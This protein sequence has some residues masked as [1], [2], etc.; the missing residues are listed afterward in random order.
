MVVDKLLFICMCLLEKV[1]DLSY[2]VLA[3]EVTRST[4][5]TLS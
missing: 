2:S 4:V 3:V 1:V 5:R